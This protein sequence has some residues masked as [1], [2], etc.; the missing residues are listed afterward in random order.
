MK[1]LQFSPIL[2][3]S[4]NTELSHK[5]APNPLAI[6]N[7]PTLARWWVRVREAQLAAKEQAVAV[8]RVQAREN[9]E[10]QVRYNKD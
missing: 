3:A 2:L 4:S 7:N 8:A 6:G 10:L 5:P 9:E 1:R